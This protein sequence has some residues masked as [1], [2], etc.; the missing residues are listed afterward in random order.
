MPSGSLA[1]D[2]RTAPAEAYNDD[3]GGIRLPVM[4]PLAPPLCLPAGIFGH[5]SIGVDGVLALVHPMSSPLP[6][7]ITSWSVRG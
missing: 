7:L 4:L 5:P 3:S 1:S 6:F 2:L